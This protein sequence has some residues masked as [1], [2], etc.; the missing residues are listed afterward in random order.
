M[1]MTLSRLM[2]RAPGIIFSRSACTEV[3]NIAQTSGSN[4]AFLKACNEDMLLMSFCNSLGC[5][6]ARVLNFRRDLSRS[7]EGEQAQRAGA[8]KARVKCLRE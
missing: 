3:S 8:Q 5:P 7:G 1:L 6:I 2:N 4:L